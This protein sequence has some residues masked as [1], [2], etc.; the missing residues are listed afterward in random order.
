MAEHPVKESMASTWLATRNQTVQAGLYGWWTE[1]SFLQR[2]IT[3]VMLSTTKQELQTVRHAATAEA[4]PV[5]S[6]TGT[7]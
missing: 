1:P 2:F 4:V 3:T 5:V 6:K 7:S